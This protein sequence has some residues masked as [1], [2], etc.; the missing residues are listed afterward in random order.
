MMQDQESEPA[1]KLMSN[2]VRHDDFLAHVQVDVSEHERLKRELER[3]SQ[4]HNALRKEYYELSRILVDR[5]SRLDD[6]IKK[7]EVK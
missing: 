1:H 5:L 2:G 6:R 4:A 3:L 7:L